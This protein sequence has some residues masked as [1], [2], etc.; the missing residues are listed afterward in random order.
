MPLTPRTPFPAGLLWSCVENGLCRPVSIAPRCFQVCLSLSAPG[1]IQDVPLGPETPSPLPSA[2]FPRSALLGHPPSVAWGPCWSP[3]ISPRGG[4]CHEVGDRPPHIVSLRISCLH[5]LARAGCAT[6]ENTELGS[7]ERP[8][9][10]MV[11]SHVSKCL[12]ILLHLLC[13]AW[14]ESVTSSFT[15]CMAGNFAIGLS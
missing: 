7:R 14:G 12:K 6:E 11:S 3:H 4:G 13:K 2:A 9:E 8:G 1:F 10:D 5:A 15:T